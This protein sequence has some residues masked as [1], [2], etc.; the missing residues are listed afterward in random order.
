MSA[1]SKHWQARPPVIDLEPGDFPDTC[2]AFSNVRVE[3]LGSPS[4]SSTIAFHSIGIP[5]TEFEGS[6]L[7]SL[8]T[9]ERRDS[10]HIMGDD[11]SLRVIPSGNL[12]PSASLSL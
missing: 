9:R 1:K 5:S 11:R 4:K 3:I 7:E 10:P 12:T 8:P 2:L 6:D